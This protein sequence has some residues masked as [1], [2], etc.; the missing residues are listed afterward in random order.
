MSFERS[1]D[2][3]VNANGDWALDHK[4][5]DLACKVLKQRFPSTSEK[6]T[7]KSS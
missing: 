7:C 1:Q 6:G 3:V 2:R 4:A 5:Y